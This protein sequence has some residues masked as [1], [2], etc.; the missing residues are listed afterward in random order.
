MYLGGRESQ[1]SD[2][3]HLACLWAWL[4]NISLTGDWHPRASCPLG[5]VILRKVWSP[6]SCL[7]L[8]FRLLLMPYWDQYVKQALFPTNFILVGFMAATK[9]QL[10]A[11]GDQGLLNPVWHRDTEGA[12][13]LSLSKT[14]AHNRL[15]ICDTGKALQGEL[16]SPLSH[17]I[18]EE[19]YQESVCKVRQ[20]KG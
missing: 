5:G 14:Q 16:R 19:R 10:R 2:C 20:V 6:V 15:S 11:C 17:P 7:E 8:L 12:S 18:C 13:H 4:W 3:F 1:L 9:I